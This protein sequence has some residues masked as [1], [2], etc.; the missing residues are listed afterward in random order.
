MHDLLLLLD[1]ALVLAHVAA[2]HAGTPGASP[3]PRALALHCVWL[4]LM[5]QPPVSHVDDVLIHSG[6]PA[7]GQ[8]TGGAGRLSAWEREQ[9]L[10]AALCNAACDEL[11]STR[12]DKGTGHSA[13]AC[14]CS[15]VIP[16]YGYK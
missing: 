6:A 15:H 1:D 13:A 7:A 12:W 16:I 8:A 10:G 2:A 5:A 4:V 11:L 9:L 3:L 14:Q